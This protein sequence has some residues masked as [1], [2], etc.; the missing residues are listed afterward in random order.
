MREKDLLFFIILLIVL[1]AAFVITLGYPPRARFFPI[2]VISFCGVF[3]LSELAKEFIARH[4]A[5]S[6]DKH[7]QK[8]KK[9]PKPDKGNRRQFIFTV[10]WIGAFALLIWLLG[11][12]VGLPLFVFAYVKTHEEG[13]RWAIILPIIMFLIVYV[14]FGIL[15]ERPLYEGRLFIR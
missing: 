10:T 14:G 11:F 5:S 13:W 3:V 6:S 7:R 4:K 1:A 9:A 8:D 12:V 2:I 15:M